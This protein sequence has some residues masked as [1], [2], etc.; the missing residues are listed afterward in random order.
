VSWCLQ[1]AGSGLAWGEI[2]YG[3]NLD[4]GLLV[5]DPVDLQ[6]DVRELG[7]SFAI[8][9]DAGPHAQVGVRYDRYNADRDAQIQAGVMNVHTNEIFSALDLIA[10]ARLGTPTTG[11]RPRAA[12]I[13]WWSAPR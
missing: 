2:A 7:M 6:R 10:A 13:A 8:L 9:Q 11:C 3:T 5:A 1:A 12:T 4:R